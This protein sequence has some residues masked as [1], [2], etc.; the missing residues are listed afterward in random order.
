MASRGTL[1]ARRCLFKCR[2]S[3]TPPG[4]SRSPTAR[5]ASGRRAAAACCRCHHRSSRR[6]GSA[7]RG[8][9]CAP[10]SVRSILS[11][12]TRPRGGPCPRAGRWCRTG[13][14]ARPSKSARRP[15]RRGRAGSTWTGCAS[16]R[17]RGSSPRA[18]RSRSSAA[19][20]RPSR[21]ARVAVRVAAGTRRRASGRRGGCGIHP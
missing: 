9:G 19:R 3:L 15:R 11:P 5:R 16:A 14:S 8:P 1:S 20:P 6:P 4:P 10:A 21:L 13:G 12:P 17:N 2:A 18:L 7:C